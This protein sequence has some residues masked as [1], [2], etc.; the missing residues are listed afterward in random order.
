MKDSKE[1]RAQWCLCFRDRN[2]G[3]LSCHPWNKNRLS[4]LRYGYHFEDY[5]NWMS[6]RQSQEE[7]K[8]YNFIKCLVCAKFCGYCHYRWYQ[9]LKKCTMIKVDIL[10]YWMY[11]RDKDSIVVPGIPVHHGCTSFGKETL[12]D[13]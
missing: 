12:L 5:Q 9:V 1:M 6:T 4:T 2:R 7:R 13:L 8:D 10:L 3:V 11:Q